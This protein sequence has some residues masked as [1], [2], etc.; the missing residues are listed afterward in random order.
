MKC[1]EQQLKVDATHTHVIGTS[2][3]GK[4]AFLARLIASTPNFVL[5]DFHRELAKHLPALHNPQPAPQT[6][7]RHKNR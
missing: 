4:S 1:N 2:A 3:A 6:I 7:R 5:L